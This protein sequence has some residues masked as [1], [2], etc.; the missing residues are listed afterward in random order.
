MA[1]CC[2]YTGSAGDRERGKS[3]LGSHKN[4]S[5]YRDSCYSS[6]KATPIT[7]WIQ[8]SGHIYSALFAGGSGMAR[9]TFHPIH[10]DQ[11]IKGLHAHDYH[12]ASLNRAH[13][14]LCFL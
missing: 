4:S 9:L 13:S 2:S 5:F 14:S 1:A 3:V 6:S 10:F 7:S 11:R 8:A 12:H